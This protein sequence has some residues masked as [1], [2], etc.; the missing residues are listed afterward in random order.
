MFGWFRRQDGFEWRNYVRTTILIRR[1]KR[2]QK[3]DEARL[4]ALDG[5]KD[6]GRKGAEIGAS[7]I[8]AAGRSALSLGARARAFLAGAAG[9][10]AA[11]A[12]GCPSSGVA[13][14]EGGPRRGHPPSPLARPGACPAAAFCPAARSDREPGPIPVPGRVA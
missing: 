11:R 13:A 7:G 3:L 8:E 6:A 10:T 4:A 12:G 14:P 5:L 9:A 2:R 1:E